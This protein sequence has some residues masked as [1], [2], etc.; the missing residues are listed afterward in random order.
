MEICL[1]KDVNLFYPYVNCVEEASGQ[2][3]RERNKTS[4]GVGI[5]GKGYFLILGLHCQLVLLWEIKSLLQ[6][7]S[8]CVFLNFRYSSKYFAQIYRAQY[9]AAILVYLCGTP[10]W[11]PQNSVII[12]NLLWLSRRLIICTEET[13]IYISTFPSTLTSKMAKYHK[14]R[15]CFLTNVFVALC[16]APP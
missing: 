14:I 15:I 1:F 7:W 6:V 12:F 10:T 5:P 8:L 4:G 9:G 3:K 11:R 13:S 16:H 2:W